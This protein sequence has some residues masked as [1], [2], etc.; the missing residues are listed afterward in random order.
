[1]SVSQSYQ[2]ITEQLRRQQAL[3]LRN[4]EREG[5]DNQWPPL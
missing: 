3:Q 1:M 2:A 4:I 5:L